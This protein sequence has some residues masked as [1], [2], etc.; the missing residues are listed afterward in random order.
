MTRHQQRRTFDD[1][2]GYTII[3]IG[4]IATLYFGAHVLAYIVN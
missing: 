2:M 1:Y 3:T 4:V